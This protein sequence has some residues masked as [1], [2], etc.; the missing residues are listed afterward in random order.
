M[1]T[2]IKE[3]HNFSAE[4]RVFE[5]DLATPFVSK[6]HPQGHIQ[7]ESKGGYKSARSLD[8]R[9]ENI[10]SIQHAY[11]HVSG[12]HDTTKPVPYWSTLSTTVVEGLNIMEILTADRVVGQI[13]VNH[14]HDGYV[15]M[16][17][18]QGTR[19]ENLRIAGKPVE[20]DWDLDIFGDKPENDGAYT[21][22]RGVLGRVSN[23][24][25][26]IRGTKGLPV[27]MHDQ[28]NQLD[29]TLGTS[30]T[31][32]CSLVNQAEGAFPG[33]AWGNVIHVPHFGTITLGKLTLQHLNPH[34]QTNAPQKTQL[35]LTMIDLQMGCVIGGT[36]GIGSGG[37]G[38]H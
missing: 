7:L 19:I 14:P 4:A 25:E 35:Q 38:G 15:P 9:L 21:K 5:A 30:E 28:Y 16:V 34:P 20:L 8:Y 29:S 31:I 24:Y 32:Q 17:H 11:S 6:V 36:G 12:I 13:V 33:T 10:I 3:E 18:F 37:T 2:V 22:E 1:S 23:Q 26:R 27:T